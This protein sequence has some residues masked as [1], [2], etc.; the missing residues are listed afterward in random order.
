L[1]LRGRHHSIDWHRFG[2]RRF[3]AAAELLLC[4]KV[5]A[6]VIPP[7]NLVGSAGNAKLQRFL[8]SC[9]VEVE[10]SDL[11]GNICRL[12]ILRISGGAGESRYQKSSHDGGDEVEGLGHFK[13]PM[14]SS[15]GTIPLLM[16]P[17][18]HPPSV[19]SGEQRQCSVK[20]R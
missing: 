6:T 11:D 20:I 1:N 16:T 19:E 7:A 3:N 5:T 13:S 15:G 12:I 10:V 14:M 4:A 17:S 18:T 8:S 2:D 9:A